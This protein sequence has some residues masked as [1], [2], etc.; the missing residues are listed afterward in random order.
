MIHS[1]SGGE[2]KINKN[3]DFAKVELLEGDCCGLAF[4]YIANGKLI[5]EGSVVVVPFGK[6]EHLVKGKVVRIDRNI[7]EQSAPFPIKR[8]KKIV[9]TIKD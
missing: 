6:N 2:L 1:L 9:N 8:M 7:N 5:K 3:F 4:W